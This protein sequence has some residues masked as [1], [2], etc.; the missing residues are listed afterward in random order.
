LA[1]RQDISIDA[2][3]RIDGESALV[4]GGGD[5]LGRIAALA[6]A[7]AGARVAVSDIDPAAARRVAGEIRANGGSA[8]DYGLDVA[9][10]E[11]IEAV[12]DQ[13]ADDFGGLG[14]LVNNAGITRQGRAESLRDHDWDEVVAVNMTGPFL[15]ARAAAR[16]MLKQGEGRIIQIASI[17]GLR[18]N[19]IFPHLAYQASKGALVN[20]TRALAVEWAGRGIRVNAIAP[21]FFRTSLGADQ[22]RRR[23]PVLARIEER[24]PMGRL[25]EPEEIAGAII[26]L[27]SPAS[28]MVTGHIL[29]IDGGWLAA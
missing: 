26:Y 11:R 16:H 22:L 1:G 15:C 29:A 23:P 27:A 5:G 7:A 24:T 10:R 9:D 14:I 8:R 17:M 20:M 2:L 19:P 4:T 18:G 25:G 21:A 6:L 28:S 13:V 12:V 3:F